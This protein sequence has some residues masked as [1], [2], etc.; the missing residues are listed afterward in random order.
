M[1]NQMGKKA[2]YD[3]SAYRAVRFYAKVASG[4]AST[5]KVLF[6]NVYSDADGGKCSDLDSTKRCGD[7]L[8]KSVSGLKTTWDLYEVKFTELTQQAFGLPQTSFDPTG[9][10]SVQFT[11]ANKLPIDLWVDDVTFVSK[12][13]SQ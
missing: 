8:F 10:Y 9:L 1:V 7:H 13:A 11:L 6:P 5:V 2:A 4:S 12:S 3:V